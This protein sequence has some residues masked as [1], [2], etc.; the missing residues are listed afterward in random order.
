ME[1]SLNEILD[2]AKKA[3]RIVIVGAGVRGKELLTHFEKAAVSVD[4]F[5]DNNETITGMYI[6]GIKITKPYKMEG[7]KVLYVVA[8]D[9]VEARKKLRSQLRS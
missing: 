1:R 8:V 3:N 2:R 9:S 7:G 4:A 5:F 6:N